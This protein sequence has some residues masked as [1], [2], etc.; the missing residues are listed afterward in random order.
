MTTAAHSTQESIATA[1][2]W[3]CKLSEVQSVIIIYI[4]KWKCLTA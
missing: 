2:V 4:D 3:K 1:E